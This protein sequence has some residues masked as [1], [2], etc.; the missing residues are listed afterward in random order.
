LKSNVFQFLKLLIFAIVFWSLAFSFFIVLR[1]YALNQEPGITID[2]KFDVSVLQRVDLGVYLG[3]FVGFFYALIEFIFDKYLLKRLYLGLS[4]LM[5]TLIYLLLLII[6]G[7]LMLKIS[8]FRMDVDLPNEMG[9]WRTN[10]VFRIVLG[11]FAVF[12]L[13]FSFVRIAIEKFGKGVFFS[14]LIGKYRK[15]TEERRVFMFLDL[16]SSTTIAEALGHF[17]YSK[18][19]QDCFLDLNHVME[20]YES[21]VYQYV[22]DEAVLSWPYKKGVKQNNCLNLFFAFHDR[23]RKRSAYYREKYNVIPEFKAGLHGGK[24][25]VVEVGSVKKELAFHGDA[26]NT[27]SRI[28]DQCNIYSEKLLI[29]GELLHQLPLSGTYNSKKIGDLVLKGKKRSLQIHAI[30]RA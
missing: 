24:L 28:Q 8:E 18:L 27:T 14:M 30:H 2:P 16:K 12:S 3:I 25:I 11:Y 15:P 1:Y 13:I 19:I 17:Q 20:N 10:K 4:I 6:S 21:E 26:I 9:W 22:G 5:R 7:T 29:S 23:I